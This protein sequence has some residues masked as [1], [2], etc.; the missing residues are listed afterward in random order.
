MRT[1][2]HGFSFFVKPKLRTI[3]QE[4]PANS[5]KPRT[6]L[7]KVPPPGERPKVERVVSGEAKTR[8]RGLGKQFKETFIAGTAP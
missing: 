8:K 6:G 3:M 5:A 7:L 4:F 1:P 2:H